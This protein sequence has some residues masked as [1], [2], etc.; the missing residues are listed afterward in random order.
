MLIKEAFHI[1][2]QSSLIFSSDGIFYIIPFLNRDYNLSSLLL[3]DC[4]SRSSKVLQDPC[5]L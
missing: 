3:S 4:N 2:F 5:G 1:T